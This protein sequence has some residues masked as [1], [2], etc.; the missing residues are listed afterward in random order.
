M[1]HAACNFGIVAAELAGRAALR[2]AVQVAQIS[3]QIEDQI[4]GGED[5]DLRPELREAILSQLYL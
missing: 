3:G 2:Y 4:L 1:L 5:K